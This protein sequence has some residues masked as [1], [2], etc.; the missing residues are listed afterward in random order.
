MLGN[1]RNFPGSS[2][3]YNYTVTITMLLY[4]VLLLI[5]YLMRVGTAAHGS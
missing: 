2:Y 4:I 1:K 5:I 3:I